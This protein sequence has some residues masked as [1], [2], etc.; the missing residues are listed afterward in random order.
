MLIRKKI[1]RHGDARYWIR[2][3]RRTFIKGFEYMPLI[4]DYLFVIFSFHLKLS[5]KPLRDSSIHRRH[6]GFFFHAY[7]YVFDSLLLYFHELPSHLRLHGIRHR[8]IHQ[9]LHLL[10]PSVSPLISVHGSFFFAYMILL[11]ICPLSGK[12]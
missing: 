8:S 2:F 10:V 4:V 1:K 3:R 7:C 5:Q 11:H 9:T 12:G 6:G